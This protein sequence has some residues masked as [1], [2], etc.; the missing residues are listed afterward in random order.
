M[1]DFNLALLLS[2][3]PE[4]AAYHSDG[5]AAP[6][7]GA[8]T[9]VTVDTAVKPERIVDPGLFQFIVQGAGDRV[10]TAFV[11]TAFDAATG[12]FT[13]DLTS[14][15]TGAITIQSTYRHSATR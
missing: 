5:S 7:A 13:F 4:Q 3:T 12:E 11:Q 14:T 2:G 10:I 8:P 6:A 1:A 9:S 15:G